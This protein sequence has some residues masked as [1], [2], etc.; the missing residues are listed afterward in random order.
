MADETMIIVAAGLL[1]TTRLM[2][3]SKLVPVAV[4]FRIP[5]G[6]EELAQQLNMYK[7]GISCVLID[8][9]YQD[10]KGMS[11]CKV[12]RNNNKTM[13]IIVISSETDRNYYINAIRWGVTSFLIKPFK[14]DALRSKLL[15]CYHSQSE[16][17]VDMITFDLEKYLLGEF[18]KA[19][20]G[21]YGISF[22]IATIMLDDPEGQGN[23]MS[24]AYYLNLLFE[25][26]RLLF[27]DTDAFIR[28]N[29]KY[30]LG[31]FPFCGRKN[32]PILTHKINTAFNSLCISRNLPVYVKLVTAFASYPE[33][34]QKFLELQRI[35]ADKVR[36]QMGDL[37]IDWFI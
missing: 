17:A 36:S 8:S 22:M 26:M 13:P 25:A 14:E 23:L 27:W 12:V 32:L 21:S 9:D 6:A 15:E 11:I 18:R 33:D 29:S 20:K 16:K 31:V 28:L 19:E 37:K 4:D 24:Q 1:E 34:S 7:Q 35:L 2:V 3:R 5:H 30:F 10:D